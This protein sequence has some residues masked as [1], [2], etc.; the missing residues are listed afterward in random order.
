[1]SEC[2]RPLQRY[3]SSLAYVDSANFYGMKIECIPDGDDLGKVEK[4]VAEQYEIDVMRPVR[5]HYKA[6]P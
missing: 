4:E 1:M 5:R 3:W 6:P 2:L